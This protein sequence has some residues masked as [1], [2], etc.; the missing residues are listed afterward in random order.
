[1]DFDDLEECEGGLG[2]SPQARRAELLAAACPDPARVEP[3]HR[4]RL[5]EAGRLKLVFMHGGGTN[6]RCSMPQV[7]NVFQQAASFGGRTWRENVEVEYF[8][9]PH[10][11]PREWHRGPEMAELMRTFGPNYWVY[12]DFSPPIE[13]G[14][15]NHLFEDWVGFEETMDRFGEFLKENGPFDGLVGFDMGAAVAMQ[16]ARR[17]AE[18]DALFAKRF[19][20]MIL[21]TPYLPRTTARL[22]WAR[23]RAPLDIPAFVSFSDAD[24]SRPYATFEEVALFIARER[25]VVARHGDAHVPP[26][27][28]EGLEPTKRLGS[29]LHGMFTDPARWRAPREDAENVALQ[30]VWLPI[31]RVPA[32]LHEA[33]PGARR[34]LLVVHEPDLGRRASEYVQLLVDGGLG[35]A[36]PTEPGPPPFAAAAP[37]AATNPRH[38]RCALYAS[39]AALTADDFRAAAAVDG[40]LDVEGVEYGEEAARFQWG[41]DPTSLPSQVALD[42]Q[43]VVLDGKGQNKLAL[44]RDVAGTLLDRFAV[45][46]GDLVGIVG[47]GHGA[48]IALQAAIQLVRTRGSVPVGFWAVHGPTVLPPEATAAMDIEVDGPGQLVDCPVRFLVGEN[49]KPGAPWRWEVQTLG[50]FSIGVFKDAKEVPRMVL[51]EWRERLS[52]CTE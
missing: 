24:F 3:P 7:Q 36:A 48:F 39:A 10:A 42:P 51:Q 1:M 46:R 9:G 29:F 37:K 38:D 12:W 33:I 6:D 50:P 34:V 14:G 31:A 20:F 47:I 40:A 15:I 41:A 22:A 8:C 28:A 21:F 43:D 26:R 2:P 18:G 19:H 4:N 25:R 49:G 45:V 13:T 17:A 30:G 52:S 16:A 44:A 11:V 32:P 27:L 35:P 5:G 23:P